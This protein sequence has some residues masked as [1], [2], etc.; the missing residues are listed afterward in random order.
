MTTHAR[1]K[2]LWITVFGLGHMR[3]AP[4]TWGSLPPI[5]GAA[6]LLL[7]GSPAWVVSLAALVGLVAWSLG[8]VVQGDRAEA[9]FAGKDPSQVVADEAAGQCIALLWLPAAAYA[10]PGLALWTLV[11]C[12]LSFRLCDIFK[13]WPA[14]ALQRVPGGWGIL[15]D[16]LVAG[17]YALVLVH[18]MAG[19]GG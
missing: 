3:P 7:L 8:C 12:F 17:L 18:A 15:L 6:V 11:L 14:N 10:S 5:A 2:L 16:D 9:R 1:S 4:G 19:L 13:P